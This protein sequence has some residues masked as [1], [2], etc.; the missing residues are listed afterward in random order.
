MDSPSKKKA[1]CCIADIGC[2]GASYLALIMNTNIDEL[3]CVWWRRCAIFS[4]NVAEVLLGPLLPDTYT[5]SNHTLCQP[6]CIL[7]PS[8]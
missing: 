8:S 5:K 4:T 6:N 1:S 3:L 2:N 7:P